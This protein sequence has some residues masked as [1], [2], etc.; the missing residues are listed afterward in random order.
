[1]TRAVVEHNSRPERPQRATGV[2]AE[3]E[4][5]DRGRGAPAHEEFLR[6]GQLQAH[7]PSDAACQQSDQWLQQR[8]LA[9][10]PAADVDRH[11]PNRAHR[12]LQRAGDRL[13]RE[14]AALGWPW[15]VRPPSGSGVAAATCGSMKPWCTAGMW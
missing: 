13:A 10:E 1:M 4:V 5:H 8:Y 9:S 14:E 11:Y 12:C 15:M 2:G 6:A 7:R 3:H